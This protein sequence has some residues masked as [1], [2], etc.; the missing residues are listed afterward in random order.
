[1]GFLR[2]VGKELRRVPGPAVDTPAVLGRTVVADSLR[3]RV[4]ATGLCPAGRGV[5]A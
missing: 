4:T 1:M 3:R 5:P 2:T